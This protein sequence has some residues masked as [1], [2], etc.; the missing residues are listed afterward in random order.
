MKKVAAFQHCLHALE[1]EV[2]YIISQEK[3][4]SLEAKAKRSQAAGVGD[5]RQGLLNFKPIGRAD[6]R[7]ARG[8]DDSQQGSQVAT[9]H[10]PSGPTPLLPPSPALLLPCLLLLQV[11]RNPDMLRETGLLDPSHIVLASASL[12][13]T[14]AICCW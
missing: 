6:E 12:C 2:W 4:K 7:G 8:L 5:S 13:R 1:A 9:K 14:H 10:P 3:Q 11:C